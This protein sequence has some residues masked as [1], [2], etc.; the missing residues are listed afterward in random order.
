MV[1]KY[2]PYFNSLSL[3]NCPIEF[4]YITKL[5]DVDRCHVSVSR[6]SRHCNIKFRFL[7]SITL[8]NLS[9][10][11]TFCF[12]K[13]D[14]RKPPYVKSWTTTYLSITVATSSCITSSFSSIIFLYNIYG[15]PF[16]LAMNEALLSLSV[17]TV[18]SHSS[19][20]A[21]FSSDLFFWRLVRWW[22]VNRSFIL[23]SYISLCEKKYW[24]VA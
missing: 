6:F 11:K 17:N 14:G 16:R 4:F 12:W 21:C 18:I 9:N 22:I 10:V 19:I 13:L 20:T 24:R 5:L 3:T 23:N 1:Y 7:L 15:L 2:L 8:V